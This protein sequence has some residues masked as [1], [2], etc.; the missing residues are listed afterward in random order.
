[1][2]P[3]TGDCSV[4]F[5]GSTGFAVCE[6]YAGEYC[7]CVGHS[8]FLTALLRL[9]IARPPSTTTGNRTTLIHEAFFLIKPPAGAALW[10]LPQDTPVRHSPRNEPP[11][12]RPYTN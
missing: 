1:M 7:I 11:L 8:R 4:M 12:R 3:G 9:I 5:P 2:V 6:R 10:C